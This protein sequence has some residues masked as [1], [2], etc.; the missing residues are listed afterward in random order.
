MNPSVITKVPQFCLQEPETAYS[1]AGNQQQK[2]KVA[3]SH[4]SCV[5]LKKILHKLQV[6]V[7]LCLFHHFDY[8]RNSNQ[9][10][11]LWL[12][13]KLEDGVVVLII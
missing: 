3:N 7:L 8:P 11:E 13:Q 10:V 4:K 9:L 2:D 12:P 6:L 1:M 5:K